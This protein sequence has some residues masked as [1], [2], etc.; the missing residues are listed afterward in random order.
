VAAYLLGTHALV[1]LVRRVSNPVKTWADG[2]PATGDQIYISVVSIGQIQSEIDQLLPSDPQKSL[3]QAH[4]RAAVAT[5]SPSYVLGI[6][7]SIAMRWATLLPLTLTT[8]DKSGQQ[9]A[10]AADSKLVLATAM[11]R[12]LIVVDPS[13][14]CHQVLAA[15]GLRS[16]DPYTGA[17][18][19]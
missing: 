15:H 16:F 8:T 14:Q 1:E 12:N 13:E 5:F 2:I 10:L 9:V 19:P 3:W 17:S 7:K 18:L 11:E 6:D 4:F